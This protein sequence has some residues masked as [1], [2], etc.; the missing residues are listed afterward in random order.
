MKTISAQDLKEKIDENI[1]DF[2]KEEIGNLA[3]AILKDIKS[4]QEL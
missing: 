1:E 4:G 3:Y 2:I